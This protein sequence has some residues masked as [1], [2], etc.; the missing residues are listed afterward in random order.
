[1][2]LLNIFFNFINKKNLGPVENRK[3]VGKLFF[4]TTL[5]FFA[6]CAFRISK[7]VLTEKIGNVSLK[8]KTRELYSGTRILKAKRGTI[9]DRLGNPIAEDAVSYSVKAILSKTYVSADKRKKFYVQEHNFKKV[10]NVLK[11]H[12]HIKPD[13]I[14][15]YLEKGNQKGLF[16]VEFGSKCSGITLRKK[17]QIQKELKTAGVEGIQFIENPARNYPNGKFASHLVGYTKKND[18]EDTGI[19][20]AFGLEAAF[21]ETLKGVDGKVAFEKD[22]AGHLMPGTEKVQKLAKDGN[23]LY[24]TIDLH[25]QTF[26]ETLMD[27]V[28]KKQEPEDMMAILMSAKTGEILAMSQRPTFNPDTKDGM[29]EKEMN[30]NNIPL[31]NN[32]EPGSTMKIL[33]V[34]TA[35]NEGKFNPNE[36]YLAGSCQVYDKKISDWNFDKTGIHSLSYLQGL[37]AS[38]NVAMVNLYHRV[39]SK[40][41]NLY[42]KR[43]GLGQFINNGIG[44]NSYGRLPEVNSPV[45]MASSSFGQ[46]VTATGMQ[47]MRAFSPV[48]NDGA[49]LEPHFISKIVN[50]HK[51][52][53]K[54]VMPEILGHPITAETAQKV[55]QYL[56]AVVKDRTWGVGYSQIENR[57][58]YSVP[59]VNISLKTGT[60]EIAKPN[61][62]GYIE[63]TYLHSVAIIAPTEDPQFLIYITLKSPQHTNNSMIAEIANPLLKRALE[64]Q[65]QAKA[66]EVVHHVEKVKIKNY[67]G[68]SPRNV[69]NDARRNV[70]QPIIV[71]DGGKVI[72]QSFKECAKISPNSK[73]II[74]ASG[75]MQMPDVLGWNREETESLARIMRIKI[76]SL[77]SGNICKAQSFPSFSNIKEGDQITLT[78]ES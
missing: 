25:L 1:M 15:D 71:G 31:Q 74:R 3:R 67:C 68:K 16:Q 70:L 56:E 61:G 19:T 55:R 34:A 6:V 24:T 63:G 40:T 46:S 30:W 54:C 22:S 9:Y 77:G 26:L 73:I 35:Q 72:A 4:Y 60:A 18:N 65:N 50:T 21:E 38:S 36:I 37:A 47:M 14:T 7:I 64:A 69:E 62:Q 49:L 75:N 27:R 13:E 12:L 45:D 57:Q 76:N 78:F 48:A 2:K 32:Y 66:K 41:L 10:A 53:V 59:G 44:D 52:T 8:L 51:N 28:Q 58:I 29:T 17:Q 42:Q 5:V 39:G 33:T 43:F 11:K 20:G 23:D